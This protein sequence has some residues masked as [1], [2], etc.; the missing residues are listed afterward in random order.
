MWDLLPLDLQRIG[1]ITNFLIVFLPNR[2]PIEP[3][4]KYVSLN[5]IIPNDSQ[6]NQTKSN[7]ADEK[8]ELSWK[9]R[10]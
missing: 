7:Y 2:L 10:T 6:Q 4:L 8:G 5:Q 3:F 1:K 9:G